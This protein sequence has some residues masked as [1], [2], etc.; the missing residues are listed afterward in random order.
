MVDAV[1][2]TGSP[3]SEKRGAHEGSADAAKSRAPG[4]R[5]GSLGDKGRRRN[6]PAHT[7]ARNDLLTNERSTEIYHFSLLPLIALDPP[8]ALS[9]FSPLISLARLTSPLFPILFSLSLFLFYIVSF[10]FLYP[11]PLTLF[12]ISPSYFRRRNER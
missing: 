8:T 10:F 7:D 3:T 12:T 11:L 1:V 6:E 2:T 9:S 4:V 5:E